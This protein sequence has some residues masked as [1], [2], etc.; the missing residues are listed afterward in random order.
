[1]NGV[2]EKLL[3]NLKIYGL[4]TMMQRFF[5]I[6]ISFALAIPVFGQDSVSQTYMNYSTPK[7]YEI[8]G[9]TVSGA[10]SLDPRSV[11]Q[12][13]GLEMGQKVSIPGEKITAAMERLWKQNIFGNI[14]IYATAIEENKIFLTIEMEELP[15]MNRMNITGLKKYEASKLQD[16]LELKNGDVI[17][18]NKLNRIK[19]KGVNFYREKGF[20]NTKI[21]VIKKYDTLSGG[22]NLT[23]DVNRGPRVKIKAIEISG[24]T[25]KRTD[26]PNESYRIFKQ[27]WRKVSGTDELAFT[28]KK[29]RRTLKSTKQ[30]SLV[31]FWKRSKYVEPD[32]REDLKTL[33]AA[34]NTKG[35][36]DMRMIMDSL[37]VIDEKYVKLTLNISEGPTY[38]FGK[39]DFVGN[40]RYPDEFL[41]IMLD[42]RK[43]DIFDEEK[44]QKN[45]TFNPD[46]GDINSMYYD[47]GYLTFQAIPVETRVEN[48]T[49]DMEIRI[50]EGKQATINKVSVEGNTR[51]NDYVIIRELRVYPGQLFSRTNLINSMNELRML[52]YFNDQTI[53]PDVRP[54]PEEGTADIVYK[55]EEV[56][57]DQVELSGGW[58]GGMIVGTLGFSFN[59][60]SVQ[61]IFRKERWR[62]LPSGDGQRLSIRGQSNG[63]Q[64]YSVSTS[65]TEPWLGGKKPYAFSISAYTSMQSTG[66]TRGTTQ[67]G[68]IITNGV[69]IGLGQRLQVPDPYFTLYQTL[70]YQHYNTQNF[71]QYF[72]IEDGSYKSFS[73][74]LSLGRLSTDGAIFPKTGSDISASMQMTPPYSLWNGKTYTPEMSDSEEF[75]WLEF[76]KWNFKASWFMNPVANLVLNARVRFGAIGRYNQNVGVTPFERFKLGGDGMS[77]YSF[78]GAEII[79]MR[80]YA[81]E[82]LSPDDGAAAYNK[83]TFEARYPITLNPAATIFGL[84]FVE[85]GNSWANSR[86]INPYQNYRSA[87]VGVR[88]FLAAMGMFGLD[89]GYG[90][91]ALPGT[92]KSQFHFSINQSID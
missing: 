39:V 33:A 3:N 79:G 41:A 52:K 29:I 1:M 65:Y 30:K 50:R 45:L 58:G 74:T 6:W 81:N 16:E 59:N 87:G 72:R 48:D 37:T 25:A 80:G 90:F 77:G 5:W 15:R 62:P 75:E 7:T 13:S 76:Y 70:N 4:N 44:L 2:L 64:Y 54:N 40:T 22:V 17:T 35:F 43:G 10:S 67:Y 18:D 32:F 55:V 60:F 31:R 73:Y 14:D 78:A 86:K 19:T 11:I 42:I 23:F 9:I 51:T 91:D 85:A 47:D 92:E 12:L 20:L 69:S 68:R 61:N 56:G 88:L 26:N 66:Y 49:V 36:R 89:W 71:Q 28:A 82:S 84:V 38:Y 27:L 8:G 46:Q 53:T 57:S 83:L 24:N 63:S 21:D 34:Y